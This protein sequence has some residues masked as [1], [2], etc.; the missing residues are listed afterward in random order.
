MQD[1]ELGMFT[2]P[3][4]FDAQGGI[5][6]ILTPIPVSKRKSVIISYIVTTFQI[7]L[8]YWNGFL[9]NR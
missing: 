2:M 7:Y 4:V 9:S 5:L 3:S 1:P 6:E 8:V